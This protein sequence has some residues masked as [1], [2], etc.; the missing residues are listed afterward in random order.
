MP[1]LPSDEELEVI[2]SQEVPSDSQPGLSDSSNPMTDPTE[3]RKP[4]GSPLIP[5]FVLM[6]IQ[7]AASAVTFYVYKLIDGEVKVE[8]LDFTKKLFD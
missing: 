4:L 7:E 6:D 2:G 1:R 8:K 5:S 3:K